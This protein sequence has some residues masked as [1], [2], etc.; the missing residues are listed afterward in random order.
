M[1]ISNYKFYF[2]KLIC[3]TN[4]VFPHLIK[5]F[6]FRISHFFEEVRSLDKSLANRFVRYYF[7]D[8]LGTSFF[9]DKSLLFKFSRFYRLRA[10]VYHVYREPKIFRVVKK[11]RTAFRK[12]KTFFFF[13]FLK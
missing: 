11:R 1:L 13:N 9:A 8:P 4:N 2:N 10:S 5:V 6:G 7:T 12:R 3:S